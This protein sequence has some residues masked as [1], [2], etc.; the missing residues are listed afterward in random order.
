MI[1][2]NGATFVTKR[3]VAE[4]PGGY[5]SSKK[6]GN[7]R[8]DTPDTNEFAIYTLP[9][10]SVASGSIANRFLYRLKSPQ[11]R[12]SRPT[13]DFAGYSNT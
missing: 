12:M 8:T 10:A 2:S 13:V 5:K 1:N 9:T 6:T 3:P 11:M 4:S 7:T